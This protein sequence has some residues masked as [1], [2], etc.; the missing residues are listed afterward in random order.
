M[1]FTLHRKALSHWHQDW[2][3]ACHFCNIWSSAGLTTGIALALHLINRLCGARVAREMVVWFRR[4]G[5]DPQLSPWLRY[6]NHLHP[7][8]HRAQDTV[9]AQPEKPWSLS[10]LARKVHVNPRHLARLF[11]QHPGISLRSRGKALRKRR[12]RQ[13]SLP[14]ASAGIISSPDDVCPHASAALPAADCRLSSR[15]KPRANQAGAASYRP[16]GVCVKSG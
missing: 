16:D 4:P 8:I 3:P 5:D 1:C 13:V 14:P 6:R 12:W 11:R 7:A 2:C 9:I 15:R 10:E